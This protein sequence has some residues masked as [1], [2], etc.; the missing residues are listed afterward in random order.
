[1]NSPGRRRRAR[2]VILQNLAFSCAVIVTLILATLAGWTN[3][4]LGVIGHEG[5]TLLVVLN[6]LRLLRAQ[7]A[8][9]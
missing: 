7:R 4:T 6:G 1:M 5:N 2:R 3:L 8:P 9:A